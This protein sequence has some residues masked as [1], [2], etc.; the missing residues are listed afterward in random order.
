MNSDR[1]RKL[2]GLGTIAFTVVLLGIAFNVGAQSADKTQIQA[3]EDQLA[4]A[5]A[6]N[7]DNA[8]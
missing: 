2:F 3:L 1:A 6:L 7:T 8:R 5:T 4:A